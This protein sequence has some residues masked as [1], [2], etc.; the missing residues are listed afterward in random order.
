[1]RQRSAGASSIRTHGSSKPGPPRARELRQRH[2]CVERPVGVGRLDRA[3]THASIVRR[4]DCGGAGRARQRS[5]AGVGAARSGGMPSAR[6]RSSTNCARARVDAARHGEGRR[7]ERA[8]GCVERAA[9]A[10]AV[11]A[12]YGLVCPRRA[13]QSERRQLRTGTSRRAS[14]AL[15][16][17][18]L[19]AKPLA[20]GAG[21]R[22]LAWRKARAA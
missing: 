3:P 17:A 13:Q 10:A 1:M 6:Q 15:G 21:R 8:A 7:R 5:R 12:V 19:A 18:P 22:S 11:R 9:R 20:R 16:F 2:E 14:R 4:Y